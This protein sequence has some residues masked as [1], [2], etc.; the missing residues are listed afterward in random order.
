MRYLFLLYGDESDMN[1]PGS[2]EM[3]AEMAAY[4]AFDELAGDAVVGGEALHENATCRTIRHDGATVRVT[5]GPF[6]ETTEGLGGFYVMECSTLD[7][8]IELARNIPAV[9]EGAIEIRPMVQWFDRSDEV[10]ASTEASSDASRYLATI[11]G[12]ES[13]A[14]APGTEAWDE[15]AAVHGRFVEGAAAA[16]M[17]GGAVQ[18]VATATTVRVR[19]GEL[20]ATDGPFSETTEV[21]GGFYVLRGSAEDVATVAARIP[22][23]EKGA[24]ELRPIMELDG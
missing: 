11:H 14:D 16:V 15:G 23:D 8:A 3:E 17:A 5:N 22:V 4:A 12:P 6:A 7:E 1:E 24:V 18:P 2:A 21:V 10:G 9:N 19:D 20:L 13:E